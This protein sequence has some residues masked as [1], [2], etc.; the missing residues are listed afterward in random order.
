MGLRGLVLM[1]PTIHPIHVQLR[2]ELCKTCPAPCAARDAGTIAFTD[3]SASCPLPR[4][5][6][7]TRLGITNAPATMAGKPVGF[8]SETETPAP[9]DTSTPADLF[10]QTDRPCLVPGCNQL[11]LLYESDVAKLGAGCSGCQL[12]ALQRKYAH[13]YRELLA[14][15]NPA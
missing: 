14:A 1:N 10:F 12:G 2:Q 3:P 6:W 8:R 11:R 5:R 4:P 9:A 15:Q 13:A 7:R